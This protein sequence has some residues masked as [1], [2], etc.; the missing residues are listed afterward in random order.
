MKDEKVKNLNCWKRNENQN[1][2]QPFTNPARFK[3]QFYIFF[4]DTKI[5]L[6]TIEKIGRETQV[7]F[8]P[9]LPTPYYL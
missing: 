1:F 9:P 8:P 3:K 4:K 2:V 7:Y 6:F 5:V